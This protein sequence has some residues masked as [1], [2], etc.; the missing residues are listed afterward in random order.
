M[1]RT[2][3]IEF[4]R[5]AILESKYQLQQCSEDV[6]V[7][8]NLIIDEYSLSTYLLIKRD[9]DI[10]ISKFIVDITLRLDAKFKKIKQASWIHSTGNPL[11]NNHEWWNSTMEKKHKAPFMSASYNSQQELVI[12]NCVQFGNGSFSN[13]LHNI[14]NL[15]KFQNTTSTDNVHDTLL[16]PLSE[17]TNLTN[18]ERK[19]NLMLLT[20]RLTL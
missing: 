11:P 9:V 10:A 3:S 18:I 12:S 1:F 2:S 20:I 15:C 5:L 13:D 6:E 17:D 16:L 7:T 14:Y 4:L 8:T 19:K